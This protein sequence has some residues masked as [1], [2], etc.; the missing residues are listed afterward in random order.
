MRC[1][2]ITVKGN[3]GWP[4]RGGIREP[5]PRIGLH[6]QEDF[7]K[8]AGLSPKRALAGARGGPLSSRVALQQKPARP[9]FPKIVCQGAFVFRNPFPGRI[10]PV[11]GKIQKSSFGTPGLGKAIA[12]RG[13]RPQVSPHFQLRG[14][15]A[16]VS[17]Q[18]MWRASS[19]QREKSGEAGARLP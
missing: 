13:S 12:K 11:T 7:A 19:C 4:P 17:C 5:G 15:L 16:C 18:P 14:S 8:G 3:L 9:R 2:G 10:F 1:N 6:P